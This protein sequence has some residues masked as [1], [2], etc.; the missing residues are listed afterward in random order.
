MSLFRVATKNKRMF[1]H[2]MKFLFSLTIGGL[3]LNAAAATPDKMLV[4]IGTYTGGPSKGIYTYELNLGNGSLRDLGL[5][6]EAQSP[7]FLA[8]HPNKKFLYAVVEGGGGAVGAFAIQPDGKLKKLNEES[9]KGAGNCHVWVDPS[10][11]NVLSA[12]YGGG[13]IA[14]L[15]IRAAQPC[16]P[17]SASGNVPRAIERMPPPAP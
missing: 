9:T 5:A 3:I 16:V 6:A 10:G 14:S 13:S 8:S 15:P 12:S 11:K 4:F 2:H 1:D 17:N 7:S